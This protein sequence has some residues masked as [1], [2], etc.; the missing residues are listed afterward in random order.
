MSEAK[1]IEIG[2]DAKLAACTAKSGKIAPIFNEYIAE[3]S[4][5]VDRSAERQR[6]ETEEKRKEVGSQS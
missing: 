2:L 4:E 1:Y 3:V 6:D 5:R